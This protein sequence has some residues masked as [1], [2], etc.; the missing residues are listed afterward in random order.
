[1]NESRAL[2]FQCNDDATL[3]VGSN[4]SVVVLLGGATALLFNRMEAV[5]P[6]IGCLCLVSLCLRVLTQC[7]QIV[8]L[9]VRIR[10]GLGWKGRGRKHGQM[11]KGAFSHASSNPAIAR[12]PAVARRRP[13]WFRSRGHKGPCAA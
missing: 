10:V 1:M 4:G 13:Y 2:V 8:C 9:S 11:C 12:G 5:E 3:L 7:C 6:F